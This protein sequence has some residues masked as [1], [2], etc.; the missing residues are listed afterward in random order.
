MQQGKHSLNMT[1]GDLNIPP[2]LSVWNLDGPPF[3]EDNPLPSDFKEEFVA[4][5]VEEMPEPI[6]FAR[7]SSV[8]RLSSALRE[9][10]VGTSAWH[11]L[12][13]IL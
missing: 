11:M 4:L 1:A 12:V 13:C 8:C 6:F 2:F 10:T 9:R 3:A 7:I 5:G